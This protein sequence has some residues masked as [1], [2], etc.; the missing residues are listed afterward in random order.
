[1]LSM[2][3]CCPELIAILMEALLWNGGVRRL[4]CCH[5][6][7]WALQRQ[8]PHLMAQQARL[9]S[10]QCVSEI[11][12]QVHVLAHVSTCLE[13]TQ[14]HQVSALSSQVL[15]PKS[16][17]FSRS[18]IESCAF[19]Y[20]ISSL[21]SETYLCWNMTLLFGSFL[22]YSV[23][24]WESLCWSCVATHCFSAVLFAVS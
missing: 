13:W 18:A 2:Y 24:L 23:L 20:L 14:Q 8:F 3:T 19:T 7:R 5:L 15:N 17:N 12:F 21:F 6:Y 9:S 16:P 1:M 22:I 10:L 11:P 4:K